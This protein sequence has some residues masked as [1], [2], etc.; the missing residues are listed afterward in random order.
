MTPGCDSFQGSHGLYEMCLPLIYSVQAPCRYASAV[1]PDMPLQNCCGYYWYGDSVDSNGFLF[2]V[3]TFV[4]FAKHMIQLL[5][6][7]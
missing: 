3:S 2:L 7:P 5:A 6:R 1:I 4:L